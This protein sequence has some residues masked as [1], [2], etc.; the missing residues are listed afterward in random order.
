MSSS[1]DKIRTHED[2]ELQIKV[3]GPGGISL[4]AEEKLD[5]PDG[6]YGW[7][8]AVASGFVIFFV[9]GNVYSFGVLY[10]VYVDVFNAPQGSVVWVGSIGA[11]LM[12]AVGMLVGALSEYIGNNKVIFMGAILIAVGYVLASFATELWHLYFTEGLIVGIGLCCG[13]ICSIEA[14][15]P[16]F[17]KHRGLAMG[18]AFSGAGLGQ[19]VFSFVTK[20]LLDQYAWRGTLR[21]LAMINGIG[22]ALASLAIKRFT[23]LKPVFT[24]EGAWHM[25]ADPTFLLLYTGVVINGLGCYMPLVYV[26]TYAQ[27][28]GVSTNHA[29]LINAICGLSS[30]LG[31]VSSGFLGDAYGD[32]NT[33]TI[34]MILSSVATYCWLVCTSF[35]SIFAY[36]L[37]YAYLAGGVMSM[38]PA[39]CA[40]VF[41]VT[42]LGPMMGLLMSAQAIGNMFSSPIGGALHD[43]TGGTYFYPIIVSATL[44]MIGGLV[45]LCIQKNKP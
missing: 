26:V 45:L 33:L 3:D 20:A 15:G 41:G 10:P 39:V 24:I 28:N 37:V 12:T 18:L 13:F 8:V 38:L 43:A 14:V 19:L 17:N 21:A 42:S 44:L 36:S 16:W 9:L 27:A 40:E 7:I 30:V 6:G 31:R 25:F 29:V 32:L 35:A 34:F 2:V 11:G 1:D 4:P 23:P 22:I 5:A